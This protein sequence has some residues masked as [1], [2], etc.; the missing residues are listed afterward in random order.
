VYIEWLLLGILKVLI[1]YYR[2]EIKM[3][4]NGEVDSHQRLF[5]ALKGERN[6]MRMAA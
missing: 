5:L 2:Q 6:E 3:L 4:I 1:Y